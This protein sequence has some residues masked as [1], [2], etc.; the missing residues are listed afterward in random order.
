MSR[1][2]G[3]PSQSRDAE[4]TDLKLVNVSINGIFQGVTQICNRGYSAAALIAAAAAAVDL[5]AVSNHHSEPVVAH[6]AV[7]LDQPQT[8]PASCWLLVPGRIL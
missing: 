1:K 8:H 5:A 6:A 7:C 4:L 2:A 3:L